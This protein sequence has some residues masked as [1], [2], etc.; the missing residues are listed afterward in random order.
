MTLLAFASCQCGVDPA[1]QCPPDCDGGSDDGGGGA[2]DGGGKSNAVVPGLAGNT[3]FQGLIDITRAT[4]DN[5]HNTVTIDINF[6][7]AS[8]SK[9]TIPANNYTVVLDL[10]RFGT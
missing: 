2:T 5:F 1:A 7:F 3:A 6:T 8:F 9:K 10:F 4:A